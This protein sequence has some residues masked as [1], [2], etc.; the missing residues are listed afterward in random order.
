MTPNEYQ[1]L[2]MRTAG[3]E[4]KERLLVNGALGI[5]GEAGEVAD[6]IKK[7]AFQGHSLDVEHLVEECGDCCWYLAIL[8]EAVG[9]TLETVMT[10]NIDK[11]KRRYPNGFSSKR[12]INREE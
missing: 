4:D 2:A 7:T 1:K 5:C 11:L 9:T 10:M 12:S 3:T 8:C 6:L